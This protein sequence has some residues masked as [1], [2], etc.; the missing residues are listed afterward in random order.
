MSRILH[1]SD[2]HF[3]TVDDRLVQPCLDLAHRMQPDL[4]VISGDL[5]QRARADQF[6]AAR[7]FMARLPGPVLVVPGNHDMPL[8][9][10]PLRL[11]APFVGYRRAFGRNTQPQVHL[12]DAVVQGV[13]T[14]N[15]LV[16]KSGRLRSSSVAQLRQTF[17]AAPKERWRVVV[18]HHAPVPAADG[19]PADIADPA[20]TLAALADA[21]A[22][23]VLSGHTHMPH[24]GF[25]ETAAGVL[26]LQVG[27]ALS[28]RLKTGANDLALVTLGTGQITVESWICA[29]GEEGFSA[30]PSVTYTRPGLEW[31]KLPNP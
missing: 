30:A 5:T 10:L 13:N 25:A 28:T 8:E 9:N 18:M 14:A 15:P 19:T 2:P 24:T 17:A 6:R 26:F 12:P 16:W 31:Q 20:E 21:G 3:G 29:S 7:D 23:V 1:L 11:L 4:C 27:T 22:D